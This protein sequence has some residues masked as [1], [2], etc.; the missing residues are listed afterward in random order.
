M[1]KRLKILL[2]SLL[3][4]AVFAASALLRVNSLGSAPMELLAVKWDETVG[5]AYY[6]LLYE[7]ECGHRYDLY[8][9][10]GLDQDKPQRLILYIHGGS[11]NSGSKKDGEMWCRYYASKG[12]IAASL[13]YSLQTVQEDASLV[14]MN[15]EIGA[16]VNA[17]RAACSGMGYS[18]DGMAPCGVSAGGTLAMNYAYTRAEASAVPVKFVFQLAGPAEFEPEDWSILKKIN[19]LDTDAEF[20]SMMTGVEITEEM[21][22]SGGA[23]RYIDGISPTRLVKKDSVPTLMGYGLKDHLVP[24]KLKYGLV[25]ALEKNGVRYDYMEFPNCNHGMYRDLDLLE[26]FLNLSIEY[27]EQ[28]F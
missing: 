27:A 4:L 15:E 24:G 5:R 25:D 17:I 26:D 9:P 3:F 13:D 6:D 11:F 12:Y 19:R 1:K 2:W 14:R 20:L 18:L 21:I 16:C 10:A 22:L 8:V 23:E 7:N 28:Y